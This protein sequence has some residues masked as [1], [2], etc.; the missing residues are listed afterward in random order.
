[1]VTTWEDLHTHTTYSDGAPVEA[2]VRAADAAGRSG[3][4]LTDHC[5]VYDDP[6]GRSDRYDFEDTYRERRS[7]IEALR[8][9]YDLEIRD[10]VEV[11]YDP[12]REGEIRAFLDA[13]GFE[14]TI[15]SV[16]YA[17]SRDV[18][19]AGSM[20]D[21]SREERRGAV[22]TYVEWQV[23][24]IDSGLFDV[25]AHVDLP[26]RAPAF[27]GLLDGED[28]R[29][30]ARALA[31]SRTVPEINAGRLDSDLGRVHPNPAHL[32]VFADEGVGFVVGSD[33]HTSG[34]LRERAAMLEKRLPELPVEVLPAEAVGTLG[35]SR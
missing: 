2:M 6:V 13:A 29:R 17:G 18:A 4:G 9:E 14:Y 20:A 24:L 16:H 27:H 31:N 23:A 7:E 35:G 28:Y 32:P 21:A 1:M 30:I 19:H 8:G 5:I 3:I 10:G 12:R 22:E 34:Q 26:E 15:G 25:A 11:N 33:S